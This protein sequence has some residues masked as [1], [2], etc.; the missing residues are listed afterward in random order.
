MVEV[1]IKTVK[2]QNVST[3]N[4]NKIIF[5]V[6]TEF[7]NPSVL[8]K[9]CSLVKKKKS[10]LQLFARTR[11]RVR[12]HVSVL[13][14]SFGVYNPNSLGRGVEGIIHVYVLMLCRGPSLELR[15]LQ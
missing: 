10:K 11:Q 7:I 6:S 15:N 13:I 2:L 8:Y 9:N 1:L 12:P 5:C 3:T 14:S 4:V